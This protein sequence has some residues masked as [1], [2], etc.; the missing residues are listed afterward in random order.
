MSPGA[1]FRRPAVLLIAALCL[2]AGVMTVLGRLAGGPR[3]EPKAVALAGDTGAQATPA[4]SPDGR[5]VAYSARG[6]SKDESFH[7]FVRAL[8]GGAPRQLTEGAANDIGPV[9]SPNGAS[10]AFLRLSGQHGECMVMPSDGGAIGSVADCGAGAGADPAQPLPALAWTRDGQSLVAVQAQGKQLPALAV[11]PL[12]GG[13]PR[14]LSRPPDGVEGDT[15]PAV[16]PDGNAVAFM[17]VTSEGGDIWLCD[18]SG[19]SLRRLTF[20]DRPIRGIAWT[21]DG[22]ELIYSAH[23]AGNWWLLRLPASGGS[24]REIRL[25]GKQAQYPALAG[26]GRLVYVDTPEVSAI[27]QARLGAGIEGTEEKPLIRSTGREFGPAFSPDGERI[28][29][30]SDESGNEEIWTA[31]RDGSHRAQITALAGPQL[32]PPRWSPDG[33]TLLFDGRAERDNEV[34]TTPSQPVSGPV[35]PNRVAL[36]S[37]ASWSRDGQSILFQ[38]RGQIWRANPDGGSPRPIVRDPGANWPVESSDGRYIFYRS[39]QAIWRVPA[40]GGMPEQVVTAQRGILWP[41][42]QPVKNGIYYSQFSPPE[43]AMAVAFFDFAKRESTMTFMMRTMDPRQRAV[44]SVSPDGRYIV[45]PRRDQSATRL[46][47][48]QNFK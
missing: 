20:D 23:R 27:W 21:P 37:G 9:W 22:Q 12:R 24:P 36:G 13:A 32:W 42:I 26:G 43:G 2:L 35:K 25:S 44:F 39:R 4:L 31:N 11:I 10:I 1:F 41:F 47:L 45:Y 15:T 38:A 8:P 14:S 19:G 30:V 7:I 40:E 34:Y 48:V 33:R 16:S 46:M 29:D 3:G 17:R 28:A 18:P 6:P 5:R